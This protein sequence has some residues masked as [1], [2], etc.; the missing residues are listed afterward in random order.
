MNVL[1]VPVVMLN[2]PLVL[3]HE[4]VHAGADLAGGQCD[5]FCDAVVEGNLKARCCVL[6]FIVR[7]L[8]EEESVIWKY[9]YN[10]YAKSVILALIPKCF[11]A[12]SLLRFCLQPKAKD[13]G[14]T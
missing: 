14:I 4:S 1:R 7:V 8:P 9:N 3:Q 12:K 13:V 5:I 6:L 10:I 11:L 2:W